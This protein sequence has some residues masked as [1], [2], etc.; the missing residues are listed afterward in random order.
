MPPSSTAPVPELEVL[1]PIDHS[2]AKTDDD[3]EIFTLKDVRIMYQNGRSGKFASLLEAYPGNALRVVGRLELPKSK[4]QFLVKKPYRPV[5]IELRNVT[6]YSYGLDNDNCAQLWALGSAGWF[7]LSPSPAYAEEYQKTEQAV[8]IMH[9]LQELHEAPVK[10]KRPGPT[11]QKIFQEYADDYP[12]RCNGPAEAEALFSQHHKI[13]IMCFLTKGM[14]LAWGNTYIY[15]WFKTKFPDEFQR[16][17]ARVDGKDTK[18]ATI[19][20]KPETSKS[21]PKES[22]TTGKH[23][24]TQD[25]SQHPRKDGSWWDAKVLYEFMQKAVNLRAVHAGHLTVDRL[26]KL[27]VRRYEIND[28]E[29]ARK[30]V[31][32]HAEN[33]RYMMAHPK[34]KKAAYLKQVPLYQELAAGH[35]LSAKE[36]RLAQAV[37]LHPRKDRSSFRDDPDSDSDSEST[38]A[39]PQQQPRHKKTGALSVLRP[40]SGKSKGVKRGKGKGKAPNGASAEDDESDSDAVMDTPTQA[41]TS[42]KRKRL[43]DVNEIEPRKRTGSVLSLDP[44]SEAVSEPDPDF[45]PS[46]SEDEDDEATQTK[47]PLHEKPRNARSNPT[48]PPIVPPLISTPLPTYSSNGPGDSWICTFD[49]CSQKIY[50]ASTDLGR[51]LIREHFQDHATGRQREVDLVLREEQRLRL[52]VN[53]LIKKIREMSERQQPLF[54]AEIE[55]PQPIRRMS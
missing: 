18:A 13:L 16:T 10:R 28:E 19:K 23:I 34:S 35:D 48:G 38:I 44:G 9:Y 30:V 54:P 53:N 46:A 17:R 55:Q 41:L 12:E 15:Q 3:Y 25:P 40:K 1:E 45:S 27:I 8:E 6:K 2:V 33:L 52:P 22:K 24:S 39:T 11:A 42:G 43:I 5:E 36:E 20:T 31:L 26:A 4:S 49:G 47:L 14:G 7:E 37:E 32:V 29:I 51:D 21:A 50:G